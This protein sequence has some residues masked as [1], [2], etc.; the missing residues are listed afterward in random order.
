MIAAQQANKAVGIQ[1]PLYGVYV[2]GR[3]WFFVILDGNKYMESLAYDATQ[4]DIFQIFAMLKKAK[5]YIE[6]QL[7]EKTSA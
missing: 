3:F 6:E 2:T 1:N 4:E 5:Y 7:D